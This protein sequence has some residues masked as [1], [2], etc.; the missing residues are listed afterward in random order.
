MMKKAVRILI[1]VVVSIVACLFYVIYLMVCRPDLL[2][3]KIL[4]DKDYEQFTAL[5]EDGIK[6]NSYFYKGKPESGTI[7]LCHGHG[8]THGYM[9]DLI[10]FL[11]KEGYS[12]L[13]FDF[14]AHGKSTG[15]L[16]TIGINEGKDVIAVLKEATK[17]G[18]IAKSSKIAGFGRSMGA[19]TLINHA[20][21]LP[22]IKA[23]ILESSFE[24]LRR[25]A[26]RDAWNNLFVP[27]T[28]V[29]D[30]FFKLLDSVTGVKYSN[31]NPVEKISGIG[32]RPVFIIHDADDRRANTEAFNALKAKLPHAI[33]WVA[34]D[35]RHVQAHS[36][37]PEEFEKRFLKF[38]QDSNI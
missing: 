12:I 16:C 19:A 9:G 8:V 30:I 1:L 36:V 24:K 23:F 37:H 33:T 29:T 32:S 14:R 5:T 15:K 18:F 11:K 38:L 17:K 28:F 3:E 21:K 34:K 2:P 4:E 20:D 10:S 26:A 7:L 13:L 35:T 6:I 25:I 31:N 27:D 22:Q